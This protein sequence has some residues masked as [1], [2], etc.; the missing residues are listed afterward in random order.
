MR[1][2]P[3]PGRH[4]YMPGRRQRRQRVSDTT[5]H[6]LC[7]QVALHLTYAVQPHLKARTIRASSRPRLPLPALPGGLARCPAALAISLV[8]GPLRAAR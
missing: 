3:G 5:A 1:N 4:A 6:R 7:D 8:Q 2:G